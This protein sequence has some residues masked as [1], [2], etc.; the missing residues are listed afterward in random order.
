LTD[1]SKKLTGAKPAVPP[2]AR[3]RSIAGKRRASPTG[4][5]LSADRYTW[6]AEA[7]Y[8][9]AERRGFEPGQDWQD[10]FEAEREFDAMGGTAG[11]GSVER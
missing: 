5:P 8:F 1:S 4:A 2:K 9:K 6:I 10:W 3:K 11:P 7:A